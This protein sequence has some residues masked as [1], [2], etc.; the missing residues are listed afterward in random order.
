[1]ALEAIYVHGGEAGGIDHTP[2]GAL[3]AGE[4]V[5]LGTYVGVVR[6]P[7]AAGELGAIHIT[8][9]HDFLKFTGEAIAKWAPVYWDEGTNTAS[10]TVGYS[11][12]LIGLC[13]KAA[14]AGDERVRVYLTPGVQL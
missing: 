6:R 4:V 10:G 11:E 3:V 5:D 2:V 12:A 13:E 1:M 7:I 9:T 8:G 14:A